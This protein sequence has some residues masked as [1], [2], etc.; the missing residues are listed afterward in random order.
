MISI[1]TSRRF[2]V[3]SGFISIALLLA[4]M[5]YSKFL[6]SHEAAPLLKIVWAFSASDDWTHCR[7]VPFILAGLIY[8]RWPELKRIEWKGEWWG[9]PVMAVSGILFW[10]GYVTDIYYLAYFMMQTLIA[11]MI[12]W[13]CGRQMLMGL[14]FPL[15]FMV[16]MWPLLFLDNW[17][18]FPLRILMSGVSHH[19]LNLV[20]VENLQIG[21]AIVSAPDYVTGLRQ[22]ERFQLDVANPCSGIRS[23]FALT[24]VAALYSYLT[25]PKLWQRWGLFVCAAPLAIFGNFIRILML[26]GGTILF[27]AKFAIGTEAE[28]STYHMIAGYVVFVIA[29]GGM[30]G[31]A[32]ILQV[33]W[34]GKLERFRIAVQKGPASKSKRFDSND[35]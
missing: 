34:R 5:P 14:A 7:F 23:L 15:M 8:F 19:F 9:L 18:A 4:W 29:I 13:F 25:L 27:G 22:G 1:L 28:P 17:I 6:I 24:M 30:F 11:G 26:T 3:A 10:F 33:D 31:I 20:G 2:A 21:T 16:F 12:L 35:Y 32:E